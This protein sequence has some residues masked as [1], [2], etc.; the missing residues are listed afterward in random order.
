M[1]H[2]RGL[3]LAHIWGPSIFSRKCRNWRRGPKSDP[4][5]SGGL[6]VPFH[7][8]NNREKSARVLAQIHGGGFVGEKFSTLIIHVKLRCMFIE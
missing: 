8:Q 4:Y 1:Y 3:S 6:S 7:L 5:K 2:A